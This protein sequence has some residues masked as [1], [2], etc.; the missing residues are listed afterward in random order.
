VVVI[1]ID[2]SVAVQLVFPEDQSE[3][4]ESLMAGAALRRERV[5]APF[6]L[7]IE[8]NNAIRQ[9]MRRQGLTVERARESFERFLSLRII[10][11]PTAPGQQA[12]LHARALE[13]A[14]RFNLPAIYDAYYLALA[15]LRGGTLWTADRR[16]IS[17]VSPTFSQILWI[18]DY[19]G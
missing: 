3:R 5:I 13:L 10:L 15:E 4:A 16:L 6:L 7:P 17:A 19:A 14:A 11:G 9:R 12:T 8:T 1:C 18:G 2:A